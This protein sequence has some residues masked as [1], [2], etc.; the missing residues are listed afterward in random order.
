MQVGVGECVGVHVLVGGVCVHMHVR[1]YGGHVLCNRTCPSCLWRQ[2]SLTGSWTHR[3]SQA[4]WPASP[5]IKNFMLGSHIA[6]GDWTLILMLAWQALFSVSDLVSAWFSFFNY[7]LLSFFIKKYYS[8][9]FYYF[10]VLLKLQ[11]DK[12]S[13]IGLHLIP[14]GF[15]WKT[16]PTLLRYWSIANPKPASRCKP[17]LFPGMMLG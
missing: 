10:F 14:Q 3:L 5:D 2:G 4:G 7:V 1:T 9:F 8:F 12:S 16:G 6:A 11:R 13:L 15:S 17:C